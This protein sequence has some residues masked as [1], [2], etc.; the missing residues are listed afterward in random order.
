ME[1]IQQ[2]IRRDADPLGGT[3]KTPT[4]ILYI[5]TI[6]PYTHAW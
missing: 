2:K 3:L 4:Y 5:H 6:F 1:W